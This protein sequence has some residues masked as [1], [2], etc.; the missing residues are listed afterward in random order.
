[1]MRSVTLLHYNLSVLLISDEPY[2]MMITGVTTVV[3]NDPVT[4]TC[5][6]SCN[7]NCNYKWTKPNNDV[8]NGGQL[9]FVAKRQD[10]GTYKCTANNGIGNDEVKQTEVQ[11]Q[12][13]CVNVRYYYDVIIIP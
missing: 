13:E 11:V 6:A 9:Q 12:C 5:S 7:P 8:I 3:E 4:L 10:Q 1:M 2:N